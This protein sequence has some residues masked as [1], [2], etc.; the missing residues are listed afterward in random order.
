MSALTFADGIR[1]KRGVSSLAND[2]S[3]FISTNQ[4]SWEYKMKSKGSSTL[5]CG[6]I[7]ITLIDSLHVT[8]RSLGKKNNFNKITVLMWTQPP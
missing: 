7:E 6:T 1:A 4:I 3:I 2:T 5:P 8:L